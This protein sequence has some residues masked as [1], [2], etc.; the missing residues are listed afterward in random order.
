MTYSATAPVKSLAGTAS[1]P[2]ITFTGDN[3]TG[4][5][6]PGA[7]QL[8][9]T[10]GGVQ[11]LLVGSDGTITP[12]GS[13]LF[14]L[15][16]VTAPS[17]SFSGDPNTGL[18]SPGADQVSVATGG[19]ERI[20]FDNNG[21]LLIGTS[22]SVNTKYDGSAFA[23]EV[24]LAGTVTSA[25]SLVRYSANT[26]G[27]SLIIGK[28]RGGLNVQSSV[29]Q[30]D[31]LGYI[32]FTGSDGAIP[33]T[34]ATIRAQ[35][36]GTPGTNDMPGRL[37]FS[38]TADG[39]ASPTERLRIDSTGQIEAGNLG[40]AAFPVWT[41]LNDP[42][43]GIFSPGA[44]QL[45]ISTNGI[46]RLTTDTAAVTS[47]L[48]VVHP[49]GAVGT[50]SITF[51]GDLNTGLY[52]PAADI[53]SV[54]T[55]GVE[56]VRFDSTTAPLKEVFNGVLY[57]VVTQIDIGTDANKIPIN[58]YLGALAFVDEVPRLR[59]GASVPQGNLDI[60]FEYVSDTSIRIR[61]RGADGTV[62]STTLTLS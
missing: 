9:I 55:G 54:S 53:C 6:S 51:A 47:T 49:I 41:Y 23:A 10:T 59:P 1:A 27:S 39:A 18:Y 29:N 19:I 56:R 11:R 35:V 38:T 21:R 50:P 33:Q 57:P 34:A 22:T 48:P 20:R 5:F 32:G 16:L 8:S 3:D 61:M 52:S 12:A 58:A 2:G 4:L 13:F 7:N 26:D 42:N 46:Q 44:D 37:V 24:Q 40:T 62:R 25:F 60:N 30:E 43:T 28:S 31:T 17:L 15:G 36:D 14:P 45:A